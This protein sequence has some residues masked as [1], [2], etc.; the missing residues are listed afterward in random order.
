MQLVGFFRVPR[1]S[2]LKAI[3]I[4]HRIYDYGEHGVKVV[5]IW[6]L[7]VLQ[8]KLVEHGEVEIERFNKALEK[9]GGQKVGRHAPL[10]HTKSDCYAISPTL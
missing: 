6:L 5:G 7:R 9:V 1:N 3:S 2:L 10:L 8:W 4:S